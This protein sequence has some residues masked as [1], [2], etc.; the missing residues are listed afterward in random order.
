VKSA[1][2]E[3]HFFGAKQDIWSIG[4]VIDHQLAIGRW[5]LVVGVGFSVASR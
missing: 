4:H 1:P 5:S 3:M 2:S